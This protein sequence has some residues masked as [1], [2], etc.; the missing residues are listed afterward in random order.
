MELWRKVVRG[1]KPWT[2]HYSRRPIR[3]SERHLVICE[4]R[5]GV[6]LETRHSLLAVYLML[7]GHDPTLPA[8][9]TPVETR[10]AA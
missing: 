3:I 10:R 7:E 8:G 1:R 4:T 6:M 5:D 9:F 2:C